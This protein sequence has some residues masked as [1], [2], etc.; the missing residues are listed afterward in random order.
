[1]NSQDILMEV[2]QSDHPIN[3]LH[4]PT[5]QESHDKGEE[6]DVPNS[7]PS[8]QALEAALQEAVRAEADLHTTDK[9]D[10]EV[11]MDIEMDLETSY[12]T[13]QNHLRSESISDISR[14]KK[15]SPEYSPVL[16]RTAR[17]NVPE[18][19]EG[20]TSFS[21]V[22]HRTVADTQ[23]RDD[24]YEPPKAT[25]P[26]E[27]PVPDSPPFSPAPPDIVADSTIDKPM[28]MSPPNPDQSNAAIEQKSDEIDVNSKQGSREHGQNGAGEL[29]PSVIGSSP[30]LVE[31]TKNLYYR[32]V[33]EFPLTCISL[34][35]GTFLKLP[36][37]PLM[38]AR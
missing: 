16:D 33:F 31:V 25:E 26:I 38:K 17:S 35:S 6:E 13:D 37:T 32:S 14:E 1:M 30:K 19:N 15:D 11:D 10:R 7:A 9:E 12:A 21:P 28:D 34:V 24:E 36:S 4:Y 20:R 18:E 8:N 22:L 29:L 3:E 23:D 5:H 27:A 2:D